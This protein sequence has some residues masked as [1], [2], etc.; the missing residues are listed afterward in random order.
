MNEK[1]KLVLIG[2]GGHCKSVLD[3]IIRTNGF[4][5]IVITD[6]EIPAG[7]KVLG[8]EVVGDDEMLPVLFEKG[9]RYAFITIG[10]I[11]STD[12]RRIAYQ[13]ASEIGFDFP[14]I[15]DPSAVI[16]SSAQIGSG[17]YIGKNAVVN[18]E[19]LIED[20]A[21]INTGAI[22]E[23]D[24]QIGKFAHIA[25]GATVCGGAKIGNDVFIGANATIIQGLTIGKNCII[26]AGRVI[27][28]D[29]ARIGKST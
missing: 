15:V 14:T 13:R 23:H 19:A 3:A 1:N 27:L 22:I 11:I 5:D 25:V 7:S 28:D 18:S 17:V 6:C 8:F 26:G 21:I 20:M 4:K 10:S 2:G 9:F 12:K 16:A 29:V 24:C